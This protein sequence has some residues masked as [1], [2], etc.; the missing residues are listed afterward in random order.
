MTAVMIGEGRVEYQDEMLPGAKA[1]GA[2]DL[3]PVELAAKEGLA[4]INGTQ[5]ST[6][7]AL[8]DLFDSWYNV[9]AAV[10]VSALSN[11]AIM[12]STEPL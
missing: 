7:Y 10:V 12:G 2:A 1:L 6:A 8:A 5:Y 4:L 11:D 9:E 3:K